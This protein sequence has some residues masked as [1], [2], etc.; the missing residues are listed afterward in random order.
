MENSTIQRNSD[1]DLSRMAAV[2]VLDLLESC[3]ELG[4]LIGTTQS[5]HLWS[6]VEA[7][8]FSNYIVFHL[9]FPASILVFINLSQ[10]MGA[11]IIPEHI[12]VKTI[13]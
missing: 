7:K 1:G 4:K 12:Q 5:R 2:E 13:I 3:V 11:F 6:K 8:L 10:T 9:F